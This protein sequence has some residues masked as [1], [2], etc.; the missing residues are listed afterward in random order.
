MIGSR[1]VVEPVAQ[2]Q[3]MAVGVRA[4]G[5]VWETEGIR[6]RVLSI[7]ISLPAAD[8]RIAGILVHVE[9]IARVVGVLVC[10]IQDVP[11]VGALIGVG[12]S[13]VVVDDDV[14]RGS[15]RCGIRGV[16]RVVVASGRA[17]QQEVRRA[18][19]SQNDHSASA[20]GSRYHC[21]GFALLGVVVSTS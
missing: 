9:D 20:H 6:P 5:V 15:E 11:S 4:E 1:S 2:K 10:Q 17:G 8:F 13:G 12:E 16:N 7:V 18:R 14:Q 3:H 19:E 21:T